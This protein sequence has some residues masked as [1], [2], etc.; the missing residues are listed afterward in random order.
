MTSGRTQ[1]SFTEAEPQELASN[2]LASVWPQTGNYT[3]NR[4]ISSF[5]PIILGQSCKLGV[6]FLFVLFPV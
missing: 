1:A 3:L 5:T 6:T 2:K 4:R